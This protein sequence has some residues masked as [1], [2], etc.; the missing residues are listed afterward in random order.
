[1]PLWID[2]VQAQAYTTYFRSFT[3]GSLGADFAR[4]VTP[5]EQLKKLLGIDAAPGLNPRVKKAV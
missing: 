1:V 4:G 5:H 3:E 2:L